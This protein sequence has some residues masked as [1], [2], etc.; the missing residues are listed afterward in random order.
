MIQHVDHIYHRSVA[1]WAVDSWV[2]GWVRG[3]VGGSVGGWVGG[4]RSADGW[5]GGWRSV[6]EWVGGGLWGS[7]GGC[8]KSS[9]TI[10]HKMKVRAKR[11][12]NHI[13]GSILGAF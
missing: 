12:L 8:A 7:V 9:N 10:S 5:V 1:G 13:N 6:G 2:R 11:H 3:W 4:W